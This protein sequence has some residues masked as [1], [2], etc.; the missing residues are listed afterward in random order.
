MIDLGA[1]G[2][3]PQL[4]DA[5]QVR[6]IVVVRG[7]AAVDI[8]AFV[9]VS[10][11]VTGTTGSQLSEAVTTSRGGGTAL[12]RDRGIGRRPIQGGIWASIAVM[13]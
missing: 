9:L 8:G 11:S 2:G 3:V 10:A 6:V 12:H 7:T 5:V 13:V 1:G 4:S